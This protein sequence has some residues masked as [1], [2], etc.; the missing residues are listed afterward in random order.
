LRDI[1]YPVHSASQV[2]ALAWHPERELVMSG[3][4]NGETHAWF[5]GRRDFQ[6]INGPHKSPIMIVE[7]SEQGGRMITADAVCRR[8]YFV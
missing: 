3:W 8:L 2:T 4:E 1:T 5:R 7:F 6:S